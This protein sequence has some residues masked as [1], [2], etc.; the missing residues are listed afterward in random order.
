MAAATTRGKTMSSG[1]PGVPKCCEV[2]RKND[3]VL[4]R[5]GAASADFVRQLASV[6]LLPVDPKDRCDQ[7]WLELKEGLKCVYSS[8]PQ[9]RRRVS[10]R[11]IVKGDHSREDG[12]D[13]PFL[14]LVGREGTNEDRGRSPASHWRTS[15]G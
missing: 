4:V 10:A 14:L 8:T 5:L 12:C 2:T 9:V 13:L 3:G 15:W 7:A 11:N 6:D 1:C